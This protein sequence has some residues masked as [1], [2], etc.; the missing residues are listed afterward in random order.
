MLV[1]EISADDGVIA[2]C[3]LPRRSGLEHMKSLRVASYWCA[4]ID[5]SDHGLWSGGLHWN[6][7]EATVVSGRSSGQHQWLR[8]SLGLA[9][10]KE[11]GGESG[12][13]LGG[14]RG[15]SR[16]EGE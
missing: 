2:L 5:V 3:P 4:H 11:L 1:G 8:Q 9:R 13:S 14:Y 16:L 15:P 10:R 12:G 6:L 7:R